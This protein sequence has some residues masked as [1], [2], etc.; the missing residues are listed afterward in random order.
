MELAL[1]VRA[2]EPE[3]V[4]ISIGGEIGEVGT[5][6]STVEELR[7][8]MDGFNATLE[9]RAPGTVGLSKISVQS[10]TTHGGVVL[11]DGSIADV[12]IDF[13]TL[14]TLSRVA[15]EEYGLSGAGAARCHPRCPIQHSTI[16][17]PKPR[18][19]SGDEIF[20]RCSMT[21]SAELRSR[22]MIGCVEREGRAHVSA[23]A[24]SS[25]QTGKG[26]GP[27]KKRSGISRATQGQALGVS[28]EIQL[29]FTHWRWSHGDTVRPS[30]GRDTTQPQPILI[31][32]GRGAPSSADLID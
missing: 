3:G 26:L 14:A 29:L 15:R 25:L 11:A 7:A 12:K 30:S 10:G 18:D 1:A 8:Y 32:G 24:D 13:D 4:T 23:S 17:A 19:S 28:R 2:L 27:F 9:K 16:P 5:E 21:I 31:S 20:R 22:S 6:N